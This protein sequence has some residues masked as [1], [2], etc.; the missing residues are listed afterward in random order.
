MSYNRNV[1]L[2]IIRHGKTTY[3]LEGKRQGLSDTP[4]C[5]IGIQEAQEL[6]N[7]VPQNADIVM[8]SP[9]IRAKQTA[10]IIY[11]NYQMIIEPLLTTYD[12][13]ELDGTLFESPIENFISNKVE[14]YNNIPFIIPNHG[15]TFQQFTTR[16][17]E[18]VDKIKS[19]Y[20][21]YSS[22]A[23]VTHSTNLEVLKALFENKSWDTYLGQAKTFH[24]F[25][26]IELSSNV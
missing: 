17:Q 9:L 10:E 5:E 19:D 1:Q 2:I 15:E 14:R 22:I 13:G 20:S 23:A 6:K 12:F 24:G 16:C 21:I 8:S 4:L 18:F 3:N 25:V 26:T 11:P 7:R